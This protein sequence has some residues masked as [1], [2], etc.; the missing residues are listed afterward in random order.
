MSQPRY[1][2][3]FYPDRISQDLMSAED[4]TDIDQIVT[5]YVR[6]TLIT[7]GYSLEKIVDLLE[8]WVRSKYA[9][10]P[11]YIMKLARAIYWSLP[12]VPLC[13]IGK[14]IGD[15][16]VVRKMV[17]ELFGN[18]YPMRATGFVCSRCGL[19]EKIN[20]ESDRTNS[21][22]WINIKLGV[23]A[24]AECKSARRLEILLEDQREHLQQL[25]QGSAV[26]VT[27]ERLLVLRTMTYS[28]YLQ[29]EEWKAQRTRSLE[30]FNNR[31]ALCNNE[32]RLHVHHRT[33]KNRG[34]ERDTDLTTLC[35]ACHELFHTNYQIMS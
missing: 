32:N 9:N 23:C 11:K 1:K 17:E 33:Y 12:D 19:E 22:Q 14:L 26:P 4:V 13:A 18:K 30:R 21:G 6:K 34:A 25:S 8:I 20:R 27:P 28:E 29:T 16:R 15:T 3:N 5:Q 35:S 7:R 2:L 31:C 24:S 10:Q